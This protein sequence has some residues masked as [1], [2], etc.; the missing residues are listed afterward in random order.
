MELI[1]HFFFGYAGFCKKLLR[2]F[3]KEHKGAISENSKLKLS[4]RLSYYI[5]FRH[6][7]A[8]VILTLMPVSERGQAFLVH[9]G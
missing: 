5:M 4:F 6:R 3:Y 8:D 7:Q 1:K 2:F 9:F